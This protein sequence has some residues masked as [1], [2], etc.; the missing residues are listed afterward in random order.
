MLSA[1][2]NFIARRAPHYHRGAEGKIIE[3]KRMWEEVAR[4]CDLPPT[5][6]PAGISRAV[7]ILSCGS[8]SEA[9]EI[10]RRERSILAA[11]NKR[12]LPPIKSI[13]FRS[14]HGRAQ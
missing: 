5:C 4:D 11:V 10:R 3:V 8:S 1:L 14:N 6:R 2:S 9:A 12:L 13:R 7:L